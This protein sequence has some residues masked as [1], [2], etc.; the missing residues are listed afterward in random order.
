MSPSIPTKHHLADILAVSEKR[1]RQIG[2]IVGLTLAISV[3]GLLAVR[4]I[5]ETDSDSFL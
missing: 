3:I 4:G 5:S 2:W 1:K